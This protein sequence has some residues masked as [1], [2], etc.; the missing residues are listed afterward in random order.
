M[1][2]TRSYEFVLTVEVG[3]DHPAFDDPEWIADAAWG[4]LANEYG[5]TCTYGQ[6]ISTAPEAT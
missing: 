1:N 2:G 6:I 3:A 5:I 4:T